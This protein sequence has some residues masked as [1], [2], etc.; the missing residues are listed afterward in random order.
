MKI[1]I[2][3]AEPTADPTPLN[4][5]INEVCAILTNQHHQVN[6]ISLRELN[7]HAC[8]GCFGCWVKK[9]GECISNDDTQDICRSTIQ[10]D[11]VLWAAPLAMG[12][13][14]ALLKL[15]L[16]KSIPL[17]HPYFEVLEGE[18]HHRKRYDHYPRVGLLISPEEDTDHR[19]LE[20]IQN[21]FSR[22]AINMRSQL[23]FCQ[24]LPTDSADLAR[25]IIATASEPQ[26]HFSLIAHPTLG[27]TI[28]PPPRKITALNGSP[29]GTKSGTALMLQKFLNGFSSISGRQYELLTLRRADP[30]A[31]QEAFASAECFWLGFPLY[32]DAMPSIVKGWIESLR[33]FVNRPNNPPIGFLVQCG[34]PESLHI[35]YIE[36]YLQKLAERLGSPYLGTIAKGGGEAISAMPEPANRKLFNQLH[37][38]GQT[39]ANRGRLDPALLSAVAAPERYPNWLI[40]IFK[41]AVKLPLVNFYWNG[42]LKQNGVY[43]QRF[44][45]PYAPKKE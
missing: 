7:M 11:F 32:T 5:L 24:S 12:F 17:L 22:T 31:L 30:D 35:R 4:T 29:R 42:Q 34:F 20:I 36:Q 33:P 39:F 9:P 15:S 45:Q 14:N 26:A 13:P 37:Q 44:A 3:N 28:S 16:D 10:S 40:P 38:L 19:D 21:I 6:L 23:A 41:I 2:L 8:T 1:T 43:D 25:Q 27:Q 18:A